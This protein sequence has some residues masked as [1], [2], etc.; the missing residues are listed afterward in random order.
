MLI[1]TVVNEFKEVNH[2]NHIYKPGDTYPA[3]SFSADPARVAFLSQVH[4]T[5]KRIFLA[6][7]KDDGVQDRAIEQL[8]QDPVEESNYPKHT[9]GGW[10]ELS[11]GEKIQGK[12]EAIAAENEL[13]SGE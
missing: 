11:N 6:N 9:G 3:E 7:V 13:K 4:P 1:A 10:Y 5:Y 12:D 2:S 8:K